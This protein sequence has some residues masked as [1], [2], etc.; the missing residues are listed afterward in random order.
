MKSIIALLL[1]VS[2][3]S[4]FGSGWDYDHMATWGEHYPMC[5]AQD[6]SPIDIKTDNV[7]YGHCDSTFNW[8]IDWTVHNFKINNNG[9]TVNLLPVEK[10][11]FEDDGDL[12]GVYIDE[13]GESWLPLTLNENAIARLPNYHLPDG[14][15]HTEFCLHGIHF[16]WGMENDEG[17][18][19]TMDGVQYPMEVHFVHYSCEH[20][21]VG[22]TL[23]QF[24]TYE[25]IVDGLAAGDDVHQ[26]AVVGIFF[27]LTDYDN[28]L[29]DAILGEED[30]DELQY[31][32]EVTGQPSEK[33]V[34]GVY[35]QDIIPEEVFSDGYFAY[36][37]SLTT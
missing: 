37:G 32:P 3:K 5:Y 26:L 27:E 17:S 19:H 8:T 34:N 23:G 2:F 10:L 33:I 12:D 1:S 9:H 6:E 16:H 22:T 14:S 29:F 28:P 25:L 35:L 21:S 13:E 7:V 18:E 11:N 24:P 15:P 36:Q 20:A 4:T 31:P 30:L